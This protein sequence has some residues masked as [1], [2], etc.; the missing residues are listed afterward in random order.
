MKQ[1]QTGNAKYEMQT[2][3]RC[4]V[5]RGLH[6]ACGLAAQPND[7]TI[8]SP[9]CIPGSSLLLLPLLRVPVFCV[10]LPPDSYLRPCKCRLARGL[11]LHAQLR[12]FEPFLAIVQRLQGRLHQAAGE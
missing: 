10:E 12:R 6:N 11:I 7:R 2:E 1:C 4:H 9:N 8:I 3:E 5:A